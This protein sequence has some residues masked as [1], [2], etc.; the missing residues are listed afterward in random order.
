MLKVWK[1]RKQGHHTNR[2]KLNSR[3][4]ALTTANKGR[5]SRQS[6]AADVAV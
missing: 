6:L 1:I 2:F 4:G 5:E 3:D